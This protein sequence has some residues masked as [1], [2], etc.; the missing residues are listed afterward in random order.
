MLP[1]YIVSLKKDITRRKVIADKLEAWGL[2]F[3]FI[4]A[5]Y[6]KELSVNQLADFNFTCLHARKGYSPT[7]G[8]IG[9]T[10]SHINVYSKFFEDNHKWACVLEDDAIIDEKFAMFCKNFNPEDLDRNEDNALYIL[11]GQNGLNCEPYVAKSRWNNKEIGG[12]KFAKTIKS[13]KYIYR[14]CC[15]LLNV[16]LCRNLRTL[17]S[18]EF[19]LADEWHYFRQNNVFKEVYLAN[20]VEH[21]VD[22]SSSYLEIERR[23]AQNLASE[24]NA[25]NRSR[26]KKAIKLCVNTQRVKRVFLILRA[27]ALSL[28]P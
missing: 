19:F 12:Q 5:V 20:F 6:G 2:A 15:Y 28:I 13:E 1:I 21:P 17:F 25:R 22:L 3:N 4:D 24:A 27:K 23:A 14:T 9:C 10:L 18:K 7:P 16:N 8:E 11:G 26:L